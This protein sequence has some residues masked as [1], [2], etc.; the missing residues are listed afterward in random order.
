M[1][2]PTYFPLLLKLIA[3]I[4]IFN[5]ALLNPKE[6]SMAKGVDKDLSQQASRISL[7]D[8]G[9]A[10]KDSL[11]EILQKR[12]S[13]RSFTAQE[14]ELS[15]LAQLLFAA[16]GKTH[17][18]GYRTAPSAGA[19]YPLEVFVVAGQVGS[20]ASGIYK[21]VPQDHELLQ[22]KTGDKRRELAQA[23]L[24]QSWIAQAPAV[25]VITAVYE[26]VTGKYGQRGIQYTHIESG[27][28]AQNLCLQAVDLDL[29]T[30]LVGAFDDAKVQ[31]IIQAKPEET[32]L[33]LIPVGQPQ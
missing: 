13:V 26:R 11:E 24:W 32:P 16:Q 18:R 22:L 6:E 20:L 31:D 27:C 25:I 10:T 30:T 12:R 1:R 17:P 9:P 33:L 8:F 4:F 23:A 15:E 5:L 7:P 21:Y 28:A 2:Y 3:F 14:L 19:L 29:G